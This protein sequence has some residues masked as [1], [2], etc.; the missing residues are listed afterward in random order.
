VFRNTKPVA[1]QPAVL[2]PGDPEHAAEQ[3]RKGDGIPLIRA[4]VDDLDAISRQLKV[5]FPG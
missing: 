5:P 2:I 1:G 3:V 4:V